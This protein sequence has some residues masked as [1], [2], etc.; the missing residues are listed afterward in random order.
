MRTKWAGS[1]NQFTDMPFRS[2]TSMH[3]I[4]PRIGAYAMENARKQRGKLG[5]GRQYG[6][7]REYG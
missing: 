4:D 2:G 1:V 6:E 7:Y 3:L 5:N